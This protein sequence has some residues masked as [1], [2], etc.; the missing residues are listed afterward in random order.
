MH[1]CKHEREWGTQD[2]INANIKRHIEEA[3]CDG[4]HRMQLAKCRS[5][6]DN[7]YGV[8]RRG[9]FLATICATVGGFTGGLVGK[10]VPKL[11]ELASCWFGLR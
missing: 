11:A 8:L 1:E 7:L 2:E 9:V 6:V 3:D 10:A 4:G 5:D